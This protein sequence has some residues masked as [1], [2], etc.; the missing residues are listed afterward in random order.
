MICLRFLRDRSSIFFKIN[1]FVPSSVCVEDMVMVLPSGSLA[2]P[3]AI[4]PQYG[5]SSPALRLAALT[6]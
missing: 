5:F 4:M 1:I 3:R 6:I 2:L